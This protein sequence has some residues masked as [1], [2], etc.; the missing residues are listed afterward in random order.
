MEPKVKL[1]AKGIYKEFNEDN[2]ITI[3]K[4]IMFHYHRVI[5][6]TV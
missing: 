5:S 3:L 4:N 1:E 6:R 2:P